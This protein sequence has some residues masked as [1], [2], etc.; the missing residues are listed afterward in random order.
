[1]ATKIVKKQ[2]E[3][4]LIKGRNKQYG[5]CELGWRIKLFHPNS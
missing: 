3:D 5:V 2:L 4:K 1:M